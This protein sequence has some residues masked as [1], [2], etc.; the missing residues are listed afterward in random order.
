M[1]RMKKMEKKNCRNPGY[2]KTILEPREMPISYEVLSH[3]VRK[4]GTSRMP[5]S[6][7]CSTVSDH[8]LLTSVLSHYVE[9]H[10]FLNS[11]TEFPMTAPKELL[12][13]IHLTDGKIY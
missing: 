9:H 6:Q 3:P 4:H 7:P 5:Q 13:I 1:F 8:G 12:E 2:P 10:I 11:T